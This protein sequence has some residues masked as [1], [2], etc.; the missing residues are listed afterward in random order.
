MAKQS[1][2]SRADFLKTLVFGAM[3]AGS[4][5]S[6][7]QNPPPLQPGELTIADLRGFARVAGLTFTDEELERVRRD[8]AGDRSEFAELSKIGQDYGLVPPTIF[9]ALG[10]ESLGPP[11]VDVRVA[12]VAPARP[13]TD[14]DIAFLTV[15]ELGHLLRTR[16]ITSTELTSI[17][18]DRMRRFDPKLLCVVTLTE[19]LAFRQAGQADRE[20]ATGKIR[21]P[22]HGIPYGIKDL[23]AVR[24]Y[25]TQWGTAAFKGQVVDENCAVFDKL[26][27]AGAVCLAKLSLGALA[28]NDNWF[29]G[30]TKNPWRTTEG[31]SGS[32][33]G[34]ASAMAAGLVAFAIG[35]ETSGSIMS[36]S[37]RCRVTGLR[38]TF[39]SVSRYGAMCLC[40]SMDK[41]GPICRTAEDAALVLAALLGRDSRDVC[42]VDRP[43]FYRTPRHL[44]GWRVGVM[45]DLQASYVRALADL[46]ATVSEFRPPRAIPGLSAILTVE[47]ASMFDAITRDGRLSLVVENEWPQIFRAARFVS[48]V[49]YALAERV[50]THLIEQYRAAFEPF[51][52][53]V[54]PGNG[55]PM[56]Y[57]TNL[58]GHP[59]I[60]VPFEVRPDGTYVGCSIWAHP[61]E[62]AKLIGAAHLLQEKTK[63]CRQR[64]AL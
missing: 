31:S 24:G 26:T 34:S 59:Q 39:G 20:I 28:M 55:G 63:F 15:N 46:G 22:L 11:R 38:P 37:Q 40:W 29:G 25:P 45:G 43:F 50:R 23:F 27:E 53:I 4:R 5:S 8:I 7:A 33:A 2:M 52:L 47:A 49:D 21:G 58:T 10:C 61:W 16:Q 30:R 13:K 62:E 12:R 14:E 44:E 48:A 60:H 64:P 54:A 17:Y 32:S 3:A 42:S 9:R 51:D 6:F 1:M 35:T 36:P 57:Q 41:V 56:I 19:E 18:F